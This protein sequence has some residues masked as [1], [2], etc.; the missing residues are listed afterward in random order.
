MCTFFGRKYVQSILCF[1]E[2]EIDQLKAEIKV[3]Q[4]SSNVPDVG[5]VSSAVEKLQTENAKL[6]YQLNHLKRVVFFIPKIHVFILRV[7]QNYPYI[8]YFIIKALYMSVCNQSVHLLFNVYI[9]Q[10]DSKSW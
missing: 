10:S 8:Q 4:D 5:S 1:Q 3:L 2:K 9:C 7:A 6:T